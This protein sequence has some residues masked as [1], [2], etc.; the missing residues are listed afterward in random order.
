MI[1][2]YKNAIKQ[3]E[4]VAQILKLDKEILKRLSAPERFVEVNFPVK[5]DSGKFKMFKGFR[6]QHNSALGPYKGGL[7]FSPEV[8]ESEVKALSMWMSWKCAI[9]DIPYGGGKGGVI[10]NTKELSA[11]EIERL[12]RAFVRAIHELIGP[13]KDVPAPD[14]YTTPEIMNWMVEEYVKIKNEELKIKNN[15][16]EKRKANSDL[17]ATFTGKPI[18]KGGSQGRTEA[19]GQGGVYILERLAEKKNLKPEDTTIAVQ[20]AG[21]V[22]YYF[23]K[24][25]E[26]LGF[27][28]VAISDSKSAIYKESGLDIDAIMKYKESKGSF[29]GCEDC[30][31][32]TNEELLELEVDVLVPAAVENVIND[33]NAKNVKARYIIEMA[34]GPTTPEADKILSKNKVLVIP[35]VLA[36]C[37]GVTVSYFEWVQNRKGEKWTKEE[38]LSKLKEKIVSAFDAVW[39]ARFKAAGPPSRGGSRRGALNQQIDMRMGAYTLAV[40]KIVEKMGKGIKHKAGGKG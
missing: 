30:E 15:K 33:M 24:L 19:T 18:E 17:L 34:N 25:A 16:S 26:E 6:S 39:E 31:Q 36:N 1:D 23:A 32:I 13:D 8:C 14:M 37:G 7:R 12:S 4:N 9:A 28:V 5:M 22:G 29:K 10:V 20:G 40:A 2:P 11:G 38:V 35:D 3:L 27:R 21:N